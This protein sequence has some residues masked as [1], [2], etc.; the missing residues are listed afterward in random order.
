MFHVWAGISVEQTST[1]GIAGS[2]NSCICNFDRYRKSL[3]IELYWFTT[4]TSNV[5]ERGPVF[6]RLHQQTFE[7]FVSAVLNYISLMSEIEQLFIYLRAFWVYFVGNCLFVPFL[8]CCWPFP[9]WFTETLNTL[10]QLTFAC[11]RTYSFL[12]FVIGLLWFCLFFFL[13]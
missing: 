7:W 10:Q 4:P 6:P 11:D 8:L 5:W 13:T 3:P 9:S 1:H 12:Q 2:E